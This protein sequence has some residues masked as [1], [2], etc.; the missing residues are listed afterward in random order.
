MTDPN[1]DL[2]TIGGYIPM[3]QQ[4]L[5]SLSSLMPIG[6][7]D[8][9]LDDPPTGCYCG[10]QVH[11]ER[12]GDIIYLTLDARGDDEEITILDITIDEARELIAGLAAM[13]R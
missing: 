6:A 3:S 8:T 13:L 11:T 12:E 9:V 7:E 2:R 10:N 5:D 1:D 4:F